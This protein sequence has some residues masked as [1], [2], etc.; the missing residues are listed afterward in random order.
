MIDRLGNFLTPL[1]Q[2]F[3]AHLFRF[4]H[5]GKY[6][7]HFPDSCLLQAHIC[8]TE[9]WHLPEFTDLFKKQQMVLQLFLIRHGS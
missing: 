2:T 4:S 7:L 9:T 5:S 1:T 6:R 3:A 8:T